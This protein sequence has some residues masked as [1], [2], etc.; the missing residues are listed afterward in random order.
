MVLAALVRVPDLG[1]LRTAWEKFGD[2]AVPA[3]LP[4]MI[5]GFGALMVNLGCALALV[6]YRRQSGSLSRAA[7][8]SAR[9]DAFANLGIIAAGLVTAFVWV[10][11]WPD[12][13]VGLAIAIG[14]AHV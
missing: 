14:R 11:P 13:M 1:T 12:L 3:P 6:R 7:F 8:L 10:S 9:N 2:P 4:L 5:A